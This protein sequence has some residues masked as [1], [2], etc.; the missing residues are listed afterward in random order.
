VSAIDSRFARSAI[1]DGASV[2]LIRRDWRH[3]RNFPL[4]AKAK[5]L[6]AMILKRYIRHE[7]DAR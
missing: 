5:L 6:H 1:L 3:F 2:A 7:H 4:L